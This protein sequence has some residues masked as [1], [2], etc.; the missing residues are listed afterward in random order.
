M[1]VKLNYVQLESFREDVNLFLY[2]YSNMTLCELKKVNIAFKLLE[3][4]INDVKI[5]LPNY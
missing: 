2:K 3:E 1:K 4:V 5:T